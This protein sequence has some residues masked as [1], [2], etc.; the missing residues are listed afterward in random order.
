MPHGKGIYLY[1]IRF[2]R[3][4]ALRNT[5]AVR[6]ELEV[7]Q[8]IT[9]QSVL[10]HFTQFTR[11]GAAVNRKIIGKLLPGKRNI[12]SGGLMHVHLLGK[13]GEQLLTGRTP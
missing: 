5:F 13:V 3:N 7:V 6:D 2:V 1:L 10:L 9:D 11:H 4:N 12:K 8:I